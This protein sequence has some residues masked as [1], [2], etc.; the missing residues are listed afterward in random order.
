M[1]ALFVVQVA[2]KCR[3]CVNARMDYAS[4]QSN[5]RS[6]RSGRPEAGSAN[7]CLAN[8]CEVRLLAVSRR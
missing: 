3:G 7:V 5:E 4:A 8:R 1:A 6:E 2:Q